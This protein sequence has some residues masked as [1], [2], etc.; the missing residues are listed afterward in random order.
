MSCSRGAWHEDAATPYTI[1]YRWLRN[2]TAIP[3]AT[4]ATYTIT[5]ADLDTN[6]YCEARAESLTASQSPAVSVDRP[7]HRP[8]PGAERPAAPAQD[9][10]LR[11][12]HL[13]RPRDDRYAV[14]HQWL[15]DS[16][17][18]PDADADHLR[19][20]G[21]RHRPS[22]SPARRARR[23]ARRR[24]PSTAPRPSARR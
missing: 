11:A 19:R 9:D 6:L 4:S 12:R 10:V 21:D 22:R 14:T 17:A 5:T 7:A 2:S 1:T 13:G 3:G 23:R 20:P 15:R 18:I 16:V 24:T 8:R